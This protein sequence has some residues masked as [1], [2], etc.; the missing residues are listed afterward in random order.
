[1]RQ[2]IAYPLE[3]ESSNLLKLLSQLIA[4]NEQIYQSPIKK[5]TEYCYL[6]LKLTKEFFNDEAKKRLSKIGLE[7]IDQ[8]KPFEA[9]G[10]IRNEAKLLI[11]IQRD[12]IIFKVEEEEPASAK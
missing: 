8:I 4:A 3:K 7:C 1:M 9:Y 11:D 5:K 12:P 10:I 6:R 2:A